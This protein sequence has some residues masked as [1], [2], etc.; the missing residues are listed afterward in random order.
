MLTVLQDIKFMGSILRKERLEKLTHTGHTEGRRCRGKHLTN[1]F[2]QMNTR[3]GT[4]ISGKESML[5]AK[6]GKKL[7]RAM[8][9]H[10]PKGHRT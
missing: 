7:W 2:L 9:S 6:T 10:V 8:I 3:S 5:K 4:K 1:E